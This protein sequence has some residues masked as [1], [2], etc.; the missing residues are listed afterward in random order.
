VQV[1]G[2]DGAPIHGAYIIV[3]TQSGIGVGLN[4][5]NAAGKA[6]FRLPPGNYRIEAYYVSSYW[7]SVITT[8]ASE[9]VSLTSTTTKNMVLKDYPPPLWTTTGFQMLI[10]VLIAIA[11]TITI[12]VYT[13]HKKSQ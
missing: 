2:N 3:Y 13:V 10:I 12:V 6:V 11:S 4:I 5:A 1:Y 8:S 7:L 9:Q